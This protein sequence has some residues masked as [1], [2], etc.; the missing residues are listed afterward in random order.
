MAASRL[1]KSP[2]DGE[3]QRREREAGGE[4][5]LFLYSSLPSPPSAPVRPMHKHFGKAA[6]CVY[7]RFL[8]VPVCVG[9]YVYMCVCLYE[10]LM[11]A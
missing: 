10:R 1:S 7:A 9:V 8:C 2:L 4:E 3:S 6:V 11:S 5:K